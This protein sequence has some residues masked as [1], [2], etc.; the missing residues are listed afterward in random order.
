MTD[1]SKPEAQSA[2][3]ASDACEQMRSGTVAKL[4]LSAGFGY[5][6]DDDG[7]HSYIFVMGHALPR[8]A[9]ARLQVGSRVRFRTSGQGRVDEL[10]NVEG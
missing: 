2:L 5:V 8:S 4:N 6:A 9:G 1:T 10:V 3:V 7:V